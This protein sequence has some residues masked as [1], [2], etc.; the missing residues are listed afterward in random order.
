MKKRSIQLALACIAVTASGYFVAPNKITVFGILQFILVASWLVLPLLNY[1]R[2]AVMLGIV[3]FVAGHLYSHSAFDS[4]WLHWI[5]LVEYKRPA[6]DYVP[7]LPWLGVVLLGIGF[8]HWLE[9][10]SK[11]KQVLAVDFLAT[12]NRTVR[13]SNELLIKMGQHSLII[14]LVHQPIMFAGFQL[15]EWIQ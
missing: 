10:S 2:M 13:L 5:G 14:Y 4:I 1:P 9:S 3:V 8:A 6:L 7:L 11:G 15:I 12:R